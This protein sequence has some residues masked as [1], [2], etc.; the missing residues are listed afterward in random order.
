VNLSAVPIGGGV[1][2]TR[3]AHLVLAR[4]QLQWKFVRVSDVREERVVA[5][6]G[7]PTRKIRG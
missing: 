4:K 2:K 1:Q 7:F 6:R 5:T 3:E